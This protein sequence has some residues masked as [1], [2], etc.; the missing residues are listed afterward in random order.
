MGKIDNGPRSSDTTQKL[1]ASTP[2]Q[3]TQ[4]PGVEAQVDILDQ[5]RINSPLGIND[6]AL[7]EI[8]RGH[9]QP[10][11]LTAKGLRLMIPPDGVFQIGPCTM[12]VEF[13]QLDSKATAA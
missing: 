10:D 8:T 9:L 11:A 5:L 12:T 4:Q 2:P 13:C 7:D 3:T 6:A 1:S